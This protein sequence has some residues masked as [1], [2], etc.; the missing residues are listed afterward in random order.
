VNPVG[1][2]RLTMRLDGSAAPFHEVATSEAIQVVARLHHKRR[3]YWEA[4]G[5]ARDMAT[6][7]APPQQ[8]PLRL[9]HRP[10]CPSRSPRVPRAA[11]RHLAL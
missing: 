1:E 2:N 7:S 9:G 8:A 3:C 6:T 10:N 11:A 5:M 4:L